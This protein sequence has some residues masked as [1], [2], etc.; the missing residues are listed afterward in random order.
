MTEYRVS[1]RYARALLELAKQ[2]QSAEAV[3]ND[4]LHVSQTIKSSRELSSFIQNPIIMPD[5]KKNVFSEL[6]KEKISKLTYDFLMLTAEKDREVLITSIAEQYEVAYNAE[7]NRTKV[8]IITA[9]PIEQ[10]LKDSIVDKLSECFK[11][12]I[13]PSF[14]VDK[15]AIGGVIIKVNDKIIDGSIKNKLSKMRVNL[16]MGNK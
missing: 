5:K 15:T 8:K 13:L 9:K 3:L 6:F 4:L 10:T 14:V 7:F 12:V 16:I 11:S 2:S 1:I